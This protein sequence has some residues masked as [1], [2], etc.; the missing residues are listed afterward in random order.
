MR[1]GTEV[2]I[3][4]T[5][6]NLEFEAPKDYKEPV[7][8]PAMPKQQQQPAA[9]ADG[10]AGPSAAAAAEEEPEKPKFVPFVG[11][12]KRL[13]GKPSSSS[14]SPAAAADRRAAMA[15][16]AAARAGGGGAGSS[17]GGGGGSS[18]AVG[19]A[20]PGTFVSTGNRLLDKLEMDKVGLCSAGGN[21]GLITC[22][23]CGHLIS[24]C[25]AGLCHT[26]DSVPRY[27]TVVAGGVPFTRLAV[28]AGQYSRHWA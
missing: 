27:G 26:R 19:G 7:P 23:P 9:A 28:I 17:S 5:D 10:Q 24:P 11:S 8:Q 12:G 21:W 3:I 22:G 16:A 6:V 25:L 2:S 4:E 1:P 13:D 18:S 15:A 14:S 20:K